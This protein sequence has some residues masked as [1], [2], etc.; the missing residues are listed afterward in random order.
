M[1]AENASY[2]KW[3]RLALAVPPTVSLVIALWPWVRCPRCDRRVLGWRYADHVMAH[4]HLSAVAWRDTI[5][6]LVVAE[7]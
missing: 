3:A 2:V 5:E 4:V 7:K 1:S 6:A